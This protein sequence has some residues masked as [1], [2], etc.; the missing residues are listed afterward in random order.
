MQLPEFLHEVHRREI[1][2]IETL[3]D[4][5]TVGSNASSLARIFVSAY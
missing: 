3:A 2:S 5:T 4:R 1:K